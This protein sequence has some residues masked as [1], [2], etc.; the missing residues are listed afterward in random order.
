MSLRA[1]ND[2][3]NLSLKKARL[4]QPDHFTIVKLS[5]FAMTANKKSTFNFLKALFMSFT[6]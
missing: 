2:R 6:V 1:K 4:P 3:S 5:E